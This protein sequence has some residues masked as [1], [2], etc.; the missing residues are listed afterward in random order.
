VQQRCARTRRPLLCA[1]QRGER[2]TGPLAHRIKH[3]LDRARQIAVLQAQHILKQLQ[4]I[5]V[6]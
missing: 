3:G 4:A 5:R 1:L 6:H 2:I